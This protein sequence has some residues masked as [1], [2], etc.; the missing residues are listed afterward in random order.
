M[1]DL[2]FTDIW[3]QAAPAA[4]TRPTEVPVT[5]RTP[6]KRPPSPIKPVP[7]KRPKPK[8]EN[9]DVELFKR[10]RENKAPAVENSLLGRLRSIMEM[11]FDPGRFPDFV[12]PGKRDWIETGDE[13]L[14][15]ILPNLTN[16]E[17]TYL[18][19]VTSDSYQRIVSRL[20]QYTGLEADELQLPSVF[21]LCAQ[22]MEK[23]TELEKAHQRE[24]ED[25]ALELVLGLDEYKIVHEAWLNGEVEFDVRFSEYG[26]ELPEGGPQEQDQ[27]LT[28]EEE[29]NVDLTDELEDL[30]DEGLKRR[31]ANILTQGSASNKLYLFN[32]VMDTIKKM[33]EDLPQLYGVIAVCA[34]LGYFVVPFGYEEMAKDNTMIGTEEVTP[35]DDNYVIKARGA[36]FP[37]LVSELVKGI[38]E[39][40]SIRETTGQHEEQDTLEKE[41]QDLIVGPEVY[42]KVASMVPTEDRE[43]LPLIRKYLL[44]LDVEDIRDLLGG[45]EQIMKELIQRAREA[46]DAYVDQKEELEEPN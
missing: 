24:L 27:E 35:K 4:P 42:N 38:E 39:W 11:A 10:S 23:T 9:R 1:L 26:M 40:I 6:R 2:P 44:D 46:W 8:G 37:L 41:T 22:T 3:E 17:Q 25:V 33:D 15:K 20:E 28:D 34:Q 31:V 16:T 13:E 30:D 14:D 43:L 5:P 7:R 29:M 21:S 12:D 32:M 36:F 45:D 18:E 19:M